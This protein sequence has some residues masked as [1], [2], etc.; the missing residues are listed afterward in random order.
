MHIF[1]LLRAGL[2]MLATVFGMTTVAEAAGDWYEML[3]ATEEEHCTLSVTDSA[4]KVECA[5]MPRHKTW[6]CTDR[7]DGG[8]TVYRG[9]PDVTDST[10]YPWSADG[11]VPGN[12]KHAYLVV[13]SADSPLSMTC[14]V[15]G[16]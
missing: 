6:T 1:Q 15:A 12:T 14:L 16:E 11:D 9:G 3:D 4:T 10:G 13:A 7:L 8:K 2:I 5:D